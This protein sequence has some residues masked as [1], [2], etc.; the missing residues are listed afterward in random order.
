MIPAKAK[1]YTNNQ[2]LHTDPSVWGKDSLVFRPTRWLPAEP[3]ESLI[4]P[5]KGSF[6]PW[7]SG[8]RQ[9]PGQK[10]AQVEFVAVMA[11]LFRKLN[12]EPVPV[13]GSDL[14]AA[15]QKLEASIA[16]SAPILTLQMRKPKEVAL[17]WTVRQ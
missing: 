14:K 11:S 1:V 12:V 6:T 3:Q 4:Q 17:R 7:S 13:H 10:M 5:P 8:P 16:D 9:C 2:S 15:Q